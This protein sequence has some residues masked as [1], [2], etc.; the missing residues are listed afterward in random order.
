M[1]YP[2]QTTRNLQGN[3]FVY[4]KKTKIPLKLKFLKKKNILIIIKK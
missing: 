2:F 3:P 1:Q 4:T